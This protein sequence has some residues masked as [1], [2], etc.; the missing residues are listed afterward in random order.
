[1]V[2]LCEKILSVPYH[3]SND[4]IDLQVSLLPS[5][6]SGAHETSVDSI[7]CSLDAMPAALTTAQGEG[8]KEL[9]EHVKLLEEMCTKVEE[10]LRGKTM[11]LTGR[12]TAIEK[13]H[14]EFTNF[15]RVL[16]CVVKELIEFQLVQND[17]DDVVVVV[18]DDDD[19]DDDD[20]GYADYTVKEQLE[21]IEVICIV[22]FLSLYISVSMSMCI[23]IGKYSVNSGYR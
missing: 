20:N 16:E 9:Q 1:M 6:S 12:K 23:I 13:Y 19:D 7:E 3:V 4:E 14:K 17:G 21:R 15:Q 22:I 18:D 11:A 5:C 10:K 8:L 2:R